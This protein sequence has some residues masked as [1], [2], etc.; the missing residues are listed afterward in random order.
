MN[1]TLESEKSNH[2]YVLKREG[3]ALQWVWA[4]L[5]FYFAADVEQVPRRQCRRDILSLVAQ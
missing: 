1:A 3:S 4:C 2:F 5:G